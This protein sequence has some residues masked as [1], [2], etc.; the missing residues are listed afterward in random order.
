MKCQTP[1]V[2]IL[3]AHPLQCAWISQLEC[4]QSSLRV[5]LQMISQPEVP[6]FGWRA[7]Q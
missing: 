7:A 6:G 1:P 2:L 4:R 5:S 3:E